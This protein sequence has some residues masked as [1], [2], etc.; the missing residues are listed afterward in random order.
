[1]TDGPVS[2][3]GFRTSQ[4]VPE[5]CHSMHHGF[6]HQFLPVIVVRNRQDLFSVATVCRYEARAMISPQCLFTSVLAN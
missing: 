1:M 5:T 3:A 6:W 4:L 2:V